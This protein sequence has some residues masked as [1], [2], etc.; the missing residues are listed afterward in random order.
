[1]LNMM[2]CLLCDD[3]SCLTLYRISCTNPSP[4]GAYVTELI[5]DRARVNWDNM[6]DLNCI[7][8]QYRIR[9]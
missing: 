6:N 7:V 4:T 8:D 1:M 5:H 3:G 2:H 9:L